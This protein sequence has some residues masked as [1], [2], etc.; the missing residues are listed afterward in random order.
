MIKQIILWTLAVIATLATAVYQDKTGPTHSYDGRFEIAGSTY[1]YKLPRSNDGIP[2]PVVAVKVNNPAVSGTVF[3]KRYTINE[4]YTPLPLQRRNDS[5]ITQL[6]EQPAA[7]KLEYYIVFT[8]GQETTTVPEDHANTIVIRWRDPVPA[9]IL[10]PHIIL[11]FTSMLLSARTGFEALT[12]HGKTRMLT[13][14]TVICLFVGGL[15]FGPLVQKFAFGDLWTGIPFGWDLTDNKTLIAWVVWAFALFR[16]RKTE[17]ARYSVLFAA[18]VM[19]II[20]LIPHSM[21][22]SEFNYETG[23]VEVG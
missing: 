10:I 21:M 2:E 3:Y 16:H 18:L 13:M 9:F 11:M 19:L 7:G 6:P 5:L 1:S 15:I 22:G 17:M 14:I 23:E 12:P 20:F 8:A 4:P